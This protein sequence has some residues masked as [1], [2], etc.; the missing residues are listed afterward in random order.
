MKATTSRRKSPQKSLSEP[1]IPPTPQ[2]P[3]EF[4]VY[5]G[6]HKISLAPAIG[7]RNNEHAD[8]WVPLIC[9]DKRDSEIRATRDKKTGLQALEVVQIKKGR[10]YGEKWTRHNIHG[11]AY[12]ILSWE[13]GKLWPTYAWY[14]DGKETEPF[15]IICTVEGELAE[16]YIGLGFRVIDNRY[17][18]E[19]IL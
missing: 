2:L 15:N 5:G 6:Y 11:P 4:R 7:P 16:Y 12:V 13:L 10:D 19:T 9:C 1:T 3:E 8:K 17:I 14:V 18:V